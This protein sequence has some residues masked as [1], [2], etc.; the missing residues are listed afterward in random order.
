MP[1]QNLVTNSKFASLNLLNQMMTNVVIQDDIKFFSIKKDDI[2][3]A[4]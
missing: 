3:L 2:T 1:C 4:N